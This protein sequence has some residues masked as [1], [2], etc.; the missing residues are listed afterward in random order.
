MF[1]LNVL[2]GRTKMRF[3]FPSHGLALDRLLLAG[4]TSLGACVTAA[5]QGRLAHAETLRRLY[6]TLMADGHK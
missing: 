4:A 5:V 3:E 2:F 1:G 6:G